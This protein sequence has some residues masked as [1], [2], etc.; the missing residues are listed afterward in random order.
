MCGLIVLVRQGINWISLA[1]VRVH[2][3]DLVLH[4]NP[5]S[6][7]ICIEERLNKLSD[8]QVF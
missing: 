5:H 7:F 4:R 8:C 1:W 2:L 3:W 6:R